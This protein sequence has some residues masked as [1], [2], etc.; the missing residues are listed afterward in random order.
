MMKVTVVMKMVSEW[1]RKCHSA[2]RRLSHHGAPVRAAANEQTIIISD[3]KDNT[4]LARRPTKEWSTPLSSPLHFAKTPSQDGCR[5]TGAVTVPPVVP[6]N[7]LLVDTNTEA[8][9]R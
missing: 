6:L 2:P 7:S 1:S 3:A 4:A 5:C 9:C 8:A